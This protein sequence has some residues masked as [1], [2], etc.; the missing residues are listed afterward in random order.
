MNQLRAIGRVKIKLSIHAIR[1][2]AEMHCLDAEYERNTSTRFMLKFILVYVV[3]CSMI[4]NLANCTSFDCCALN[5]LIV[6][7]TRK[8]VFLMR[9]E[10]KKLRAS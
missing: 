9:Q 4:N 2:C 6:L 1:V 3:H 8:K 7:I 5:T 10:I